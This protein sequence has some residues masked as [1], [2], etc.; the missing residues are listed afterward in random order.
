MSRGNMCSRDILRFINFIYHKYK[1]MFPQ[2]FMFFY[3]FDKV[4]TS[5]KPTIMMFSITGT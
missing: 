1:V 3:C 2:I 4:L 5:R